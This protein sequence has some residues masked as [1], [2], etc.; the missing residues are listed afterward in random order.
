MKKIKNILFDLGAVLIDIDYHKVAAAFANLGIKNFELQFSQL[1]ASSLFEDLETGKISEAEFH[2]AI[3]QQ[4]GM[5]LESALINNAWN[6]ILLDFRKESMACLSSLKNQYQLY[7]LSNTNA[8]HL[9]KVN[10]IASKQLGV[11]V[12]DEYFHKAYYSHVIGLR[13]PHKEA[14]QFVLDDANINPE[15][16]FFIDDTLPNIETANQMGFKTHH[17]LKGERVENIKIGIS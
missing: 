16:T 12:L 11:K 8:I 6:A 17:L 13:K 5:P 2:K 15:E 7:L 3:Q 4:T 10:E 1:N 9:T 14:F